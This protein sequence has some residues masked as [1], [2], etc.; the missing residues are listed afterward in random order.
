M[1][2]PAFTIGKGFMVTVVVPVATHPAVVVVKVYIPAFAAVEFGIVGF[3]KTEVNPF[4][5]VQL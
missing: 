1:S 3:C 5:P 2:I 4:G